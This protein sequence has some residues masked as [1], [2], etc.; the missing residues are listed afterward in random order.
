MLLS[1]IGL[2]SLHSLIYYGFSAI[3]FDTIH[4][5]FDPFV[6]LRAAHC[7]TLNT[8]A[9]IIHELRLL[10]EIECSALGHQD[11]VRATHHL[12]LLL[13]LKVFTTS[14]FDIVF[15]FEGALLHRV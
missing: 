5:L 10:D 1:D 2:H 9:S 4:H 3:S 15:V 14:C 13:L 11:S 7:I 6:A 12:L 8:T